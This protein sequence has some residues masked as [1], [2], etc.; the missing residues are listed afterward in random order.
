M[1]ACVNCGR[2]LQPGWK[3]CIFC[4]TRTAVAAT[5]PRS[6]P[7]PAPASSTVPRRAA[8]PPRTPVPAPLGLRSALVVAEA[9]A[10]TLAV[11]PDPVPVAEPV[12]VP[13]TRPGRAGRINP[14]AVLALILGVL[15]SPLGAL[16]GHV[17]LGQLRASD[18][19]GVIPAWVA[20]V[21]GYLW[22]GFF[23]VL[24]ISYLATNG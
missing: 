10:P 1:D 12:D 24:G 19:R 5:T 8:A 17:A 23:V 22:L 6:R 15:A 16:F 7:L 14:L 18:E 21:L 13:G 9:P 20:V 2:A 3:Y 11:A 4:G